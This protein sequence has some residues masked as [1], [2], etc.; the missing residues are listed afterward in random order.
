MS[1]QYDKYTLFMLI[2]FDITKKRP[3][4]VEPEQEKASNGLRV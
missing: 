4:R 2:I 3:W 1:I